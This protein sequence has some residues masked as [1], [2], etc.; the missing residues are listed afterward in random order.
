[1]GHICP[2]AWNGGP[3]AYVRDGDLIEINIPEGRVELLVSEDEMKH[4]RE[5]GLIRP[6]HQAPGMLSAYRK[7]VGGADTGAVWL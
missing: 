4:R 1:L 5:Q 7:T 2:E 6:S 3:I